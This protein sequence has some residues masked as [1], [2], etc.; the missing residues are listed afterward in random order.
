MK[1]KKVAL[2]IV[3]ISGYTQFI[4]TQKLSAIHA[5]VTADNQVEIACDVARQTRKFFKFFTNAP[6]PSPLKERIV[7]VMPAS[8]SLIF[9]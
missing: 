3:D 1:T 9:G 5:E 4:R 8:V 7:I 6:I 2:V